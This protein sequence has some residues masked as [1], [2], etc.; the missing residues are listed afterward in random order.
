M[1]RPAAD[2]S[3]KMTYGSIE[4]LPMPASRIVFGTAVD[5]M[6]AGENSDALLDGAAERGINFFDCAR[7]YGRAEEVLG[8]WIRRRGNREKVIVLTKCGDIRDG[9]LSDRRCRR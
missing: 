6:T 5:P 9:V 3:G 8:S 1:Y 2:L 4:L 7:S